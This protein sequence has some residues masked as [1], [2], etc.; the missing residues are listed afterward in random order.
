MEQRERHLALW[1]NITKWQAQNNEPYGRHYIIYDYMR[2]IV[3]VVC[4]DSNRLPG[5]AVAFSSFE[6]A[7]K[8][9]DYFKNELMWDMYEYKQRLDWEDGCQIE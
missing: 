3:D 4:F 2:R 8:C 9:I 6:K 5:N 1:R 7:L